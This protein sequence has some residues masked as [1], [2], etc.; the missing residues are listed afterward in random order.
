MLKIKSV[1]FKMN[2]KNLPEFRGNDKGMSKLGEK[3]MY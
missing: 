3:M 1:N 2:P